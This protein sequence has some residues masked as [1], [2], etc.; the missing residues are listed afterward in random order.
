[1]NATCAS[2]VAS[3][4]RITGT[5]CCTFAFARALF[6]VCE[7]CDV[8]VERRRFRF[9][10]AGA[11]AARGGVFV[12]VACMAIARAFDKAAGRDDEDMTLRD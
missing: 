2:R 6:D 11:G 9:T 7:P 10:G 3:C 1:M 12:V 8:A 5:G 4:C